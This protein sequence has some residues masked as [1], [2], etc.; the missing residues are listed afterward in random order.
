MAF[1]VHL[2][3]RANE[4]CI[5]AQR[6]ILQEDVFGLEHLVERCLRRIASRQLPTEG[7]VPELEDHGQRLRRVEAAH[8]NRLAFVSKF[9]VD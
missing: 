5:Q 9:A 2:R 4:L 7:L 1:K 3:G 6:I 8:L